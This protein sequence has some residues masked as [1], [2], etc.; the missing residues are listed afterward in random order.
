[1]ASYTSPS[2]PS[3]IKVLHGSGPFSSYAVSAVSLR[4]GA[5]FTHITT[6]TPAPKT[7]TSVQVSQNTHMELN[8]DLRYVNHSCV[9]NL[10]WDLAKMEIRVAGKEDGGDGHG[11]REGEE[12]SFFYPSSEWDFEQ[13]FECKC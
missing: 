7:Y 6:A 10:V 1:M 4:P 8:S 11:L 3:L 13:G 12:L 5:L 2:H 9:P